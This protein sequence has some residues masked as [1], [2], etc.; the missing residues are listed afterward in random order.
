M[1]TGWFAQRRRYRQYKARI[2]RLPENYAST[3]T[4]VERYLLSVS[5]GRG[6]E[7]NAMLADLV[8]LFEQAAHHGTAIADIVGDDPVEFVED[9]VRNYPAGGWISTER[10]RLRTVVGRA[11]AQTITERRAV[12]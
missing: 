10:N 6:D 2:A 4:A 9:F 12:R 1:T 11:A 5:P 3:A 8:E 7:V